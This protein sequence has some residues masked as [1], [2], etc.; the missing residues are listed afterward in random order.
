M[1]TAQD[2]FEAT[3]KSAPLW[4]GVDVAKE[5]FDAAVWPASHP[6]DVRQMRRLPT[7]R[8]ERTREGVGAFF[9]WAEKLLGATPRVVMEATGSFSP[10]LA[11]WMIAQRPACRPA[12]INPK[13]AKATIATLDPRNNTD[14][15]AARALARYGVERAPAPYEPPTPERRALRELT[16]YRVTVVEQ[17]Q[18]QQMRLQEGPHHP[19]VK[20]M[21]GDDVRR[22]ER[23]EKKLGD[24]I[25]ALIGASPTLGADIELL[26]SIYGVDWIVAATVLAELGDLRRFEQARQLTA[27]AGV[28][29]GRK[30][31]G[32][33]IHGRARMCKMGSSAV[34]RAL[35]MAA[36]CAVRG[37]NEW[38]DHYKRLLDAGKTKRAAEG[39]IMRKMLVA[40]RAIL[41]SGKPYEAH[42]K[43]A[44]G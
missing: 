35:C 34:R 14:P 4:S 22:L 37:K 18:A 10:E 33:S 28:A 42:Y 12:I 29:T 7:M 1:N 44:C 2:L 9:A 26:R 32:K 17:R 30:E 41:I 8:F 3:E 36:R 38:A 13:T 21:I 15:I 39:A 23:Q 31:S 25:R 43:A 16:R 11:V 5:W 40:M 27:F 20:R 24:E 19:T 6:I